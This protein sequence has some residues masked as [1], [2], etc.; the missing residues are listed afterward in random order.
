MRMKNTEWLLIKSKEKY[1]PEKDIR[2][3]EKSVLTGKTIS[4]YESIE[5]EKATGRSKSPC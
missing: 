3:N 2:K 5:L 1:A 4:D